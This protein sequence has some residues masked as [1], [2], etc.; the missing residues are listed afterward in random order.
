MSVFDLMD[1]EHE[2]VVFIREAPVGLRAIVAVHSTVLGPA[3]GGTRFLPYPS[4]DD[5]LVDVLRLSRGM[6]YKQAVAG[7]DY[8]GGKAVIF[9]DPHEVRTEALIRAYASH[10]DRLGGT[11]LTAED[12][13]TTQAD[14]DLIRE[15]TPHV[16]GTSPAL[17]GS[18]DPSAATAWGVLHAMKAAAADRWGD[19]S[20]DGRHVVV[21]GVGKVGSA[22][23]AH[24]VEAGA[25]VTVADIRADAV[26]P[27]VGT[28]NVDVVEHH[29]AHAEACDIY[30]PCALGAVLNVRTIPE[31]GCAVIAGAANNQ[32]ENDGDAVRLATRDFL[33]VP[34]YVANAGGVINISE[35]PAGYDRDRAFRHV[36]EIY[37]TTTEVI[38]RSRRDGI[39][40]AAAADRIAEERLE[41]ARRAQQAGTI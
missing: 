29:R 22:L 12:V 1:D 14:M 2:Q 33:Y 31:L 17:G 32:L 19:P 8:G 16:T 30:S 3:M 11:Y 36:T 20:L 34:D 18:G 37:D 5:A 24:L 26:A 25:R 6:T 23:V 13:G 10:I 38:E 9:G 15:V 35:E 21:A 40:T 39:T 41:R 4:E 7:I 28:Y 27:L